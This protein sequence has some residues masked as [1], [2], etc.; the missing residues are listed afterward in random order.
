MIS[1]SEL[2]ELP[3]FKDVSANAVARLA[4]AMRDV[5]CKAGEVILKDGTRDGGLFLIASGSVAVRK[6]V[7]ETRIKVIAHM[8]KGGFFGEMSLLDKQ[9]ASAE[10]V[11]EEDTRL[12]VLTRSDFEFLMAKAP[13]E[14]LDHVTTLLSSVCLRLRQTTRELVTV[15]E[16]ARDVGNLKGADD[17]SSS[18]VHILSSTFGAQVTVGLYRWN[19]PAR[20]YALSDS[21][22]PSGG[23]LPVSIDA[24][25][26]GGMDSVISIPDTAAGHPLAG[27]ALPGG[28]LVL[29]RSDSGARPQALFLYFTPAP[30]SFDAGDRQSMETVASV[31][32]PAFETARFRVAA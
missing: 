7:D 20:A 4:K 18:A 9:P 10:V 26:A 3:L 28:H 12:F 1:T 13:N 19:A 30:H 25:A 2:R 8:Q 27:A 17:L 29:C 6:R 16:L 15:Y 5:S 31:L 23:I 14:A 21:A 32:A 24:A 11:A 22:G